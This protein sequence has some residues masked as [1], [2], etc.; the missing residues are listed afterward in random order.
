MVVS[1]PLPLSTSRDLF[2]KLKRDAA[3]L[4]EEVTTDRF[5]NFVVTG[6]SLIDWIKADPT[7]AGLNVQSLYGNKW[8]R[9]CG[10]LATAAKHFQITRRQP[11]TSSAFSSQGYGV[12]RYGR[13][14][15]GVG[16][17]NIDITLTD[18]TVTNCLDLVREVVA[19]FENLF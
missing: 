1:L 14:G 2:H 19:A 16:E 13:G 10:D 17:E 18:G 6:W 4:D 9:I 8:I 5:F 15:Y 3:L 7:V 11:I 12:G